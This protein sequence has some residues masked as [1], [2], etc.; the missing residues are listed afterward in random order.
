MTRKQS[1][2]T[3]DPIESPSHYTSSPSGVE[4]ITVIEHMTLNVG[5]AVKYLWRHGL[6]GEHDVRER[7]IEDLK[8]ARWFIER[9][10]GRLE[11]EV[12]E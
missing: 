10:I 6:K 4:C 1:K 11:S 7:A 5:T 9:E 8:K 12:A 2:P 3:S